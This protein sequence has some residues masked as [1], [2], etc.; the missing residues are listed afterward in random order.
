MWGVSSEI[1]VRKSRY[2]Y[3]FSWVQLIKEENHVKKFLNWKRSRYDFQQNNKREKPWYKIVVIKINRITCRSYCEN[4]TIFSK[5]I[6][7]GSN[8]NLV[9]GSK[10][11]NSCG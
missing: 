11:K 10:I 7:Y 5:E 6:K 9:Y 1:F 8:T 4:R 3:L 2:I